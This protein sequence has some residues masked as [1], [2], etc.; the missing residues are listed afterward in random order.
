MSLK[1]CLYYLCVVWV[2]WSV[3]QQCLF[4][5]CA[6]NFITW[7]PSHRPTGCVT[8]V[9]LMCF[10]CHPGLVNWNFWN[11]LDLTCQLLHCDAIMLCAAV[12]Y[13]RAGGMIEG[14]FFNAQLKRQ[15]YK[16]HSV[17]ATISSR[18]TVVCHRK[19]LHW[20]VKDK[21]VRTVISL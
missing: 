2:Y 1:T 12:L 5:K 11:K 15:Q 7:S 20:P 18:H 14:C 4:F 9:T 13:R 17:T 3:S 19:K 16:D 8:L 10:S 6:V 21:C